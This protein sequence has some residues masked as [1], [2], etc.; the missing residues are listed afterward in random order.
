MR[1]AVCQ[2][3]KAEQSLNDNSDDANIDTVRPGRERRD[4]N[5]GTDR[6]TAMTADEYV[7]K[8]TAAWQKQL[9]AVFELGDLL[10][11]AKAEHP[12]EF[13][14]WFETKPMPFTYNTATRFMRIAGKQVLREFAHVQ[15]ALPRSWGTLHAM[16]GV[17]EEALKK[18]LKN[19]TWTCETDRITVE[20]YLRKEHD[21]G[22][23]WISDPDYNPP[24]D[25]AHDDDWERN[26][27]PIRRRRTKQERSRVC[28]AHAL[29]ILHKWMQMH[30]E[31]DP[32]VAVAE[33]VGFHFSGKR[34]LLQ[35]TELMSVKQLVGKVAE[36]AMSHGNEKKRLTPAQKGALACGRRILDARQGT[37]YFS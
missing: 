15:N 35:P 5:G 16:C 31:E 7:E 26:V 11:A 30:A 13:M 12:G 3:H 22:L 24:A 10:R 18:L 29:V 2:T 36:R 27:R 25:Y 9:D 1:R 17:P 23:H 20:N 8:I 37:D 6:R 4:N 14:D 28:A 33:L 19:K 32:E 34:P 21:D